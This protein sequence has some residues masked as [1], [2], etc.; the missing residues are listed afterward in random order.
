MDCDN[1]LRYDNSYA[2][3][4][5]NQVRKCKKTETPLI[6]LAPEHRLYVKDGRA[7]PA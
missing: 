3:G 2:P 4:L 5:E 6:R 7:H 1:N